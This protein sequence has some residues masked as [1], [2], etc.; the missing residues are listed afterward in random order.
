MTR[1][2]HALVVA[3]LGGG[4]LTGCQHDAHPTNPDLASLDARVKKLEA[5]NARY[6][7]SLEALK[8]IYDQQKAQAAAEEENEPAPDAVFAVD[9][10]P[11]LAAG[12]EQGPMDAPVTIV[13]AFDFA[14]P[15]CR[16]VAD[17]LEDLIKH[18]PGKVR[19]VY[20]N[21]VVHDVAKT[22]HLASCAAAKQGKY[23]AFKDAYWK[24]GFDAYAQE[25][26]PSK[27]DEAA[28]LAI[29]KNAGLDPAR[30]EADMHSQECKAQIMTDMAEL[31]KFHVDSTPTL[32]VNG[33]QVSGAQDE[34]TFQQLID[35]KLA[36]VQ[37]S[38]VPAGQYYDKVIMTKG[39]K[40]FRAKKD[41]KPS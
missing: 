10:A 13:E 24:Q 25:G 5:D 37:A 41:A 32:F 6:H 20:K 12:M 36:A 39:E 38:G 8:A 14:C 2:K 26:D 21:M 23:V 33:T 9:I 16:K 35:Q 30:L 34:S 28:V 4:I 7:E 31:E 22:V 15:Y 17:T 27:I 11:D 3:L 29:A 40:K 1:I 19:V 18:N